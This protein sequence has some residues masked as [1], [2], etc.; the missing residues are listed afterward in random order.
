MPR[1]HR[2]INDAHNQ[3]ENKRKKDPATYKSLVAARP[4]PPPNKTTGLPKK[5]FKKVTVLKRHRCP[6]SDCRF[7]PRRKSKVSKQCLQ[8]G[9]PGTTNEDLT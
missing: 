1:N 6:I 4:K 3:K 2:D 8:Q 9:F 7:S 5:I